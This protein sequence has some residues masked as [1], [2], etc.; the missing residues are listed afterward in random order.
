M[1]QAPDQLL[2]RGTTNLF[3]LNIDRRKAW[4]QRLQARG[5][6]RLADYIAFTM[7]RQQG[8]MEAFGNGFLVR[9]KDGLRRQVA[10][11]LR[12]F[13]G[14][15]VIER[16]LKLFDASSRA[17]KC[18]LAGLGAHGESRIPS[19]TLTVQQDGEPTMAALEQMVGRQ[20]ADGLVIRMHV[21][22]PGGTLMQLEGPNR[23]QMPELFHS[24]QHG[25]G[26]YDDTIDA[27]AG[28]HRGQRLQV[29]QMGD[30]QGRV[31]LVADR[32]DAVRQ[33]RGQRGA[34]RCSVRIRK[35]QRHTLES[36]LGVVCLPTAPSV[37]ARLV[38]Q[39][40]HRLLHR[41]QGL[42]TDPLWIVDR[43][44]N[45]GLGHASPFR[46]VTDGRGGSL[47]VGIVSV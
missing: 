33:G 20:L 40:C 18:L 43:E 17:A 13:P 6:L 32:F 42:S 41:G 28:H 14:G 12:E 39:F 46:N 24:R 29:S 30:E 27:P 37:A 44:G 15:T 5:I 34:H 4:P 1:R 45:R 26:A 9:D 47:H 19:A 3:G 7:A 25:A 21:V 23:G 11:L 16:E 38:P 36:D 31:L 22:A 10:A 2:G 35:E 8:S